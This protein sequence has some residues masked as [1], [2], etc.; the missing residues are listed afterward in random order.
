MNRALSGSEGESWSTIDNTSHGSDAQR[1]GNQSKRRPIRTPTHHNISA[2][3]VDEIPSIDSG[4]SWMRRVSWLRGSSNQHRRGQQLGATVNSL[5][6]W[7]EYR[8]GSSDAYFG[9]TMDSGDHPTANASPVEALHG[10]SSMADSPS[11]KETTHT[12]Q[13]PTD[14]STSIARNSSFQQFSS[15]FSSN[16]QLTSPHSQSPD[17]EDSVSDFKVDEWTPPDTS[18][19]SACPVGGW[20]PK[21]IRRL[22][23]WILIGTVICSVAFLVISTSIKISGSE[24]R[25]NSTVVSGMHY[26]D[27]PY[28]T[29]TNTYGKRN[30]D[31]STASDYS[32]ITTD[33]AQVDDVAYE[34][35]D[36]AAVVD[37]VSNDDD[38]AV[39]NSSGGSYNPD[40]DG[41]YFNYAYKN[42]SNN[43]R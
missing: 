1:L 9:G 23:E 37:D 35:D 40:N 29:F 34:T 17:D 24:S 4:L 33:D 5:E 10:S 38:N 15:W 20:I 11:T 32:N 21:T 27:D 3:E 14:F 28:S 30:N 19:G 12:D 25:A 8:A 36:E 43:F 42:R 18:Y 39:N 2:L 6:Y 26:D 7:L 16:R 13:Y 31:D 22:I 41:S